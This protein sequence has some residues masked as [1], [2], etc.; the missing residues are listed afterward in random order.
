MKLKAI[1]VLENLYQVLDSKGQVL[2]EDTIITCC[3]Y[4]KDNE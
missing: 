2:L 4:I 3:S 1:K